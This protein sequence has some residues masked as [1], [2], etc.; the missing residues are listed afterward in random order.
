MDT[1]S[2]HLQSRFRSSSNLSAINHRGAIQKRCGERTRSISASQADRLHQL[3]LQQS[4]LP[5]A[6]PVLSNLQWLTPQQSPQPLQVFSEPLSIEHFPVWTAPTPPR[7]DSGVPSVSVDA[8]EDPATTGI[9]VSP[10]F[11]YEQPT[12]M[13]YESNDVVHLAH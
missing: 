11:Q 8:S 10:D 3:A 12:E 13:R 6:P 5:E 9:T 2:P 1:H 7:S 4:S